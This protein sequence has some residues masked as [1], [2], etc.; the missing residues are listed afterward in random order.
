MHIAV[1]S[2]RLYP[3]GRERGEN[4]AQLGKHKDAFRGQEGSMKK[5][6]LRAALQAVLCPFPM[7]HAACTWD[8]RAMWLQNAGPRERG[9][10]I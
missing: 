7:N 5:Q 4:P 1:P 2:L 9:V 3:G 10:S 8:M 6:N